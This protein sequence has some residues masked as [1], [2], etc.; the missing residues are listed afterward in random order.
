MI[1]SITIKNWMS[2]KDKTFFTMEAGKEKSSRSTLA[3]FKR[4]RIKLLPIAAIFGSNG[5]GKSNFIKA[6]S[7]VQ[8]LLTEPEKGVFSSKPY[9]FC[10][11]EKLRNEPSK[12][13]IQLMLG[14]YVY[15]YFLSFTNQRIVNESL[16]LINTSSSNLLFSRSGTKLETGPALS[17]TIPTESLRFIQPLLDKNQPAL[18]VLGEANIDHVKDVFNWFKHS[19]RIITPNSISISKF[20]ESDGELWEDF[21]YLDTGITKIGYQDCKVNL[22]DEVSRLA[23]DL[24]DGEFLYYRDPKSG[25]IRVG[26]NSDGLLMQKLLAV[27]VTRQGYEVIIPDQDESEGV[28]RLFDLLP[29]MKNLKRRDASVTYFIDEFDRSLHS[30]LTEHLLNRFLYSCGAETR[31]QLIVTTQN[32]FLIN[33]DLLRRDE[34][35]IANRESDGS[36][37][38]YPMADFIELRLDKDIRKSY[39]EGRMGGLPNL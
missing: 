26:R 27:H 25:A 5:S 9:A 13:E 10:F 14:K 35:W 22:P 4:F 19:L 39:F 1:V 32:P 16:I 38:L 29:A 11:D 17:K 2:F 15:S 33:Q 23:R 30:L 24:Q 31:K 3:D 34:L 7:F 6:I 37:I 28:K 8:R 21:A 12:I 36:T 18:S 20:A